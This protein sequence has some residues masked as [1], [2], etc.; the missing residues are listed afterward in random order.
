MAVL[1]FDIETV[2]DVEAGRRLYALDGLDDADVVRAMRQLRRQRVGHDF[3][4]PYLHRI[5]AIAVVLAGPE[6]TRIWSLGE[7]KSAEPELIGR[8][9][10]GLER[11]R[12]TLVSWNGGGFDLPVLAYRALRHGLTARTYW[13]IGDDDQSFR[14]NNYVSRYHWRHVDLMDVLAHYQPRAA[15]PLD[16]IARLIG[17]PGKPG[18][19]GEDVADAWLAGEIESIRAYC[20]TDALN[21]YLI[22]LRFELLRGRLEPLAYRRQ[23][24][25]L[26]AQLAADAAPAHLREFA[27][28]WNPKE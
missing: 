10:E 17:L 20:E 24:E 15:A 28:R 23:I 13:D 18:M 5:V 25:E 11:Y 21:T 3:L 7:A 16:E 8:F 26:H 12:P 19:R 9:F 14:Y 4:A 27:A 6:G 22:W 1:A 2:P